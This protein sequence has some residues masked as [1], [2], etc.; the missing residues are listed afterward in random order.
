MRS[1]RWLAV[2]AALLCGAAQAAGVPKHGAGIVVEDAATETDT[3]IP[4]YPGAQVQPRTNN[5]SPSL[6]LAIWALGSGIRLSLVKYWSTDDAESIAAF[7][8]NELAKF[9][10][11]VDCAATPQDDSCEGDD[12]NTIELRVGPKNDR[13]I[14]G[15]VQKKDG[16]EIAAVRLRQR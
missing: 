4:L 12:S 9:G 5:N 13:R 11:V 7:Y 6:K 2:I 1:A 14:V 15:I 3:G 10:K 16:C 8:R